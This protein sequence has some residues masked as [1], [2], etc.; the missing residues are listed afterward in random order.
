MRNEIKEQLGP[1]NDFDIINSLPYLDACIH[2][3][4]YIYI[5]IYHFL[6]KCVSM[7]FSFLVFNLETLRLFPPAFLSNKICTEAIAYIN[8]NTHSLNIEKGD[9]VVLPLHAIMSDE[10]YYNNPHS[11]QPERFLE[12]NGGLKKYKDMGVYYG[13]GDGPRACLG[14][15]VILAKLKVLKH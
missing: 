2:G 5:Y 15:D 10:D 12:E 14:K 7:L 11:F 6:I 9:V 8:K 4:L 1:S 13:F 3:T